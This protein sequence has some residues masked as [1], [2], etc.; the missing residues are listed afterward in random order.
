[1]REEGW[2]RKIPVIIASAEE[3]QEVFWQALELGAIDCLK[4]PWI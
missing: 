2:V 4:T 1:M 3:N